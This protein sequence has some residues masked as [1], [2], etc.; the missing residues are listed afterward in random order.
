MTCDIL[1][2]PLSC[3]P[4]VNTVLCFAYRTAILEHLLF[5]SHAARPAITFQNSEG[6][7]GVL[8]RGA[9]HSNITFHWQTH[10]L[11][12]RRTAQA[13]TYIRSG[14]STTALTRCTYLSTFQM[15]S[16]P[17][18]FGHICLPMQLRETLGSKHILHQP[19]LGS[20]P[21][22]DMVIPLPAGP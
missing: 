18:D 8:Q 1:H 9:L 15:T 19:L 13:K 22:E 12:H 3:F 14:V 21:E 17:E 7:N 5:R 4:Q 11:R 10:C 6:K 2:G 16:L 20:W